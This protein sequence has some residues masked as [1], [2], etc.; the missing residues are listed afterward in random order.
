MRQVADCRFI[1]ERHHC[2]LTSGGL[3]MCSRCRSRGMCSDSALRR[4]LN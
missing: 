1:V 4:R 2:L 3:Y